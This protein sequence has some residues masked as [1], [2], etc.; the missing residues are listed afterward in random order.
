MKTLRMFA[1]VLGVCGA[2]CTAEVGGVS[3]VPGAPDPAKD[4]TMGTGAYCPMGTDTWYLCGDSGARPD[5][6]NCQHPQ[7]TQE[8][9][10]CCP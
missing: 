2:G 8:G 6:A 7:G 4:C 10:W 9:L 5:G 1:I 3:D